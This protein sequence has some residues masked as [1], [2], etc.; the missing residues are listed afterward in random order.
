MMK[1]NKF[2]AAAFV[3]FVSVGAY[4][5]TVDEIVDKHVAALGG[6]DKL[7][8]VTSLVMDRSLA[9]QGMEIPNKTILLV[10]KVARSESTVMGNTMVQVFSETSGWMIRPAMMG[11]TGEPEDMPA[12]MVKQQ[13][14]QLDPFGALVNYKEKGNTIELVGTEKLN[15]KDV[16]HLKV[17]SKDGQSHDE[18]VDA[19]TFLVSK[20]IVVAQGQNA[21]VE[22]SDYKDVEGV[23]YPYTL[24]MSNQMGNLAFTTNKI[25]VNTPVDE[26]IFKK[27]TK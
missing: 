17:T 1:T 10:G 22:F 12:E 14:G 11:G 3:A 6:A 23:K 9:V 19:T 8:S 7:K 25:A 24:E 27:P 15:K 20:I 16:Y 18:Y 13:A 5:Q 4:A 2:L 21:E 26:A